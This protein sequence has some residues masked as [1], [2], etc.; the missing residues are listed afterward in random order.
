MTPHRILIALETLLLTLPITL[1]FI[2]GGGDIAFRNYVGCDSTLRI[3]RVTI[4]VLIVG[5][6]GAGWVLSIRFIKDGRMVSDPYRRIAWAFA[7][8]GVLTAMAAWA[9]ANLPRSELYG[10]WDMFRSDIQ[11]SFVGL[12]LLLPMAHLI[13]LDIKVRRSNNQLQRTGEG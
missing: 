11:P 10:C 9:S 1:L 6:L 5:A 4:V 7:W 3:L 8:V 12:V 2:F 13:F